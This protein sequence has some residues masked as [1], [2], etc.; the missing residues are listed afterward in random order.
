MLFLVRIMQKISGKN[1]KKFQNSAKKLQKR[2]RVIIV[3][4]LFSMYYIV[5]TI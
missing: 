3:I 5:N 2:P 4:Y 1:R